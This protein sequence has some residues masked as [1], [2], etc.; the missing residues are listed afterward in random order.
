MSN[1]MPQPAIDYT[2]S[3]SIP[4]SNYLK[5]SIPNEDFLSVKTNSD[6]LMNTKISLPD[7]FMNPCPEEILRTS[8]NVHHD[9][10]S[11]ARAAMVHPSHQTALNDLYFSKNEPPKRNSPSIPTTFGDPREKKFVQ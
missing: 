8:R 5:R 1:S 6:K 4:T 11:Y 10:I 2:L 3:N 9:H 7:S